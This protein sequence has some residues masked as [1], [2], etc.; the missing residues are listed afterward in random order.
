MMLKVS[1]KIHCEI[2]HMVQDL[3]SIL[4][5]TMFVISVCHLYK[6]LCSNPC[7]QN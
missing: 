1:R 5:V 6:G 2:D 3:T 4:S 7:T